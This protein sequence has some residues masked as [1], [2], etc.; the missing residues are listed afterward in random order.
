MIEMKI[1]NIIIEILDLPDNTLLTNDL[2]GIGLNSISFIRL[3]VSIE[4]SFG[5]E[6]P[7]EFLSMENFSTISELVVFVEKEIIGE[8]IRE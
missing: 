3:I 2:V 8:S 7:N 6:V 1:K 5:I 4:E